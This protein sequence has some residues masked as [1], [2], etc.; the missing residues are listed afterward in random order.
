MMADSGLI[1][2]TTYVHLLPA[3]RLASRRSRGQAGISRVLIKERVM[4]KKR[5]VGVMVI[6][7]IFII[8]G[9]FRFLQGEIWDMEEGSSFADIIFFAIAPGLLVIS[10]FGLLRYGEIL[11]KVA[12]IAS[13]LEAAVILCLVGVG[14]F[15]Y[16]QSPHKLLPLLIYFI[17]IL[18]F[19]F[20]SFY[21]IR[22]KVKRLFVQEG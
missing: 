12:V 1:R 18:I 11:R 17:P 20:S 16:S 15:W 8:W 5:S 9:A 19:L 13:L 6:G 22:P 14:M 4:E 7:I 2:T 10:G 3:C 21:L